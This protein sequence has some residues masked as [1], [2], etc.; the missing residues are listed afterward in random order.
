MR[1]DAS[2]VDVDVD[3]DELLAPSTFWARF[4]EGQE[5]EFVYTETL[6][7]PGDAD[8]QELAKNTAEQ[9]RQYEGVEVSWTFAGTEDPYDVLRFRLEWDEIDAETA[10]E[11]LINEVRIQKE[12][13]N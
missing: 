1:V 2:E 5:T 13:D 3:A 11:A 6:D 12:A 4:D 7:V 8:A 10:L 9:L